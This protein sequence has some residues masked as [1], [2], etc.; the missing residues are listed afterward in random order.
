[1]SEKTTV[2]KLITT[3]HTYI[4]KQEKRLLQIYLSYKIVKNTF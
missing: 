4:Y 3:L 2:L 1:M